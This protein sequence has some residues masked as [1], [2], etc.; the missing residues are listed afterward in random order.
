MLKAYEI[1]GYAW[2]VGITGRAL[3][4]GTQARFL[5]HDG[6]LTEPVGPDGGISQSAAINDR[7]QTVGVSRSLTRPFPGFVIWQDQTPIDLAP[8]SRTTMRIAGQWELIGSAA[9]SGPRSTPR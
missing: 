5:W 8:Y 3:H 4:P 6:K 7:N 1:N 2:V 9:D